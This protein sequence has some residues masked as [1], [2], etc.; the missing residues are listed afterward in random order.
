[1]GLLAALDSDTLSAIPPALLQ[2]LQQLEEERDELAGRLLESDAELSSLRANYQQLSQTH[3]SNQ[4]WL[5]QL[6]TQQMENLERRQR[7][8]RALAA[9]AA[10]RA[11]A[12]A[13]AGAAVAGGP[14]SGGQPQVMS[15]VPMSG[16]LDSTVLET[17]D[18]DFTGEVD[19][20]LLDQEDLAAVAASAAAAGVMG[21]SGGGVAGG[22]AASL[23]SSPL[24]APPSAKKLA[25][26]ILGAAAGAAAAPVDVM[27]L[28]GEQAH[29]TVAA[30]SPPAKSNA[31]EAPKSPLEPAAK[32]AS[33][34]AAAESHVAA[35]QVAGVQKQAKGS[36]KQKEDGRKLEKAQAA[37]AAHAA[38]SSAVPAT[39]TAATPPAT[40]TDAASSPA[41]AP[42]QLEAE[43]A[44]AQK[45]GTAERRASHAVAEEPEPTTRAGV[46]G[47]TEVPASQGGAGTATGSDASRTAVAEGGTP[48]AAPAAT[49][50]SPAKPKPKEASAEAASAP[51]KAAKPTASKVAAGGSRSAGS[52]SSTLV[53]ALLVALVLAAGGT[54]VFLSGGFTSSVPSGSPAAANTRL[55]GGA[56]DAAARTAAA[57]DAAAPVV[58]A[59]G[60]EPV[61]A[62]P[63]PPPPPPPPEPP[64]LVPVEHGAVS[65]EAGSPDAL[66]PAAGEPASDGDGAADSASGAVGAAPSTAGGDDDHVGF[67]D[68]YDHD[69]E[70]DDPDGDEDAGAAAAAA[71]SAA[72]DAGGNVRFATLVAAP[73]ALTP[74]QYWCADA[75]S[76]DAEGAG[77]GGEAGGA[78]RARALPPSSPVWELL[79]AGLAEAAEAADEPGTVLARPQPSCESLRAL[80][81]SLA[82]TDAELAAIGKQPTPASACSAGSGG[83]GGSGECRLPPSKTSGS[84]YP[85]DARAELVKLGMAELEKRWRQLQRTLER[86]AGEGDAKD[87]PA[88]AQL[89]ADPAVQAVASWA[90]GHL[91]PVMAPM[92]RSVVDDDELP[93]SLKRAHKA[94]SDVARVCSE[95]GPHLSTAALGRLEAQ[96][97]DMTNI[98]LVHVD[99]GGAAA[100]EARL[101]D[102]ARCLAWMAP[103]AEAEACRLRCSPRG[104]LVGAL[105]RLGIPRALLD[106]ALTL[107]RS[108][109]DDRDGVWRHEQPP[110]E[111]A[112]AEDVAAWLRSTQHLADWVEAALAAKEDG[113]GGGGSA[114]GSGGGGAWQP[115]MSAI[116]AALNEGSGAS[117]DWRRLQLE[118]AAEAEAAQRLPAYVMEAAVEAARRAFAAQEGLYECGGC[119]EAGEGEGAGA[120][121]GGVPGPACR[122]GLRT[123]GME[124]RAVQATAGGDA[125]AAVQGLSAAVRR[126]RADVVDLVAAVAVVRARCLVAAQGVL[127]YRKAGLSLG[128]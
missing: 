108:G 63:P 68:V 86:L 59:A 10:T 117:G 45:S 110:G 82:A 25:A 48:S 6:M 99:G 103:R 106:G 102:A 123:L 67:V 12:A 29:G 47:K 91:L 66:E 61:E 22:E 73:A 33:A 27:A 126:I 17:G 111:D 55:A 13:G 97:N 121:D 15:V 38:E 53:L 39:N 37:T 56:A 75:A 74:G 20:V 64:G 105:G 14:A 51:R 114:V 1:M 124:V 122:A 9:M 109:L 113:N 26:S 115:L 57:D 93:E 60:L 3:A 77:G 104:R 32:P 70:Y 87:G 80:A 128:R 19:S 11:A 42:E 118:L 116:G 41:P 2:R 65:S 98:A 76:C 52:G 40:S 54:Y 16:L 94:A 119:G 79:R 88:T 62:P 23:G 35:T 36:S 24:K 101:G 95:S 120:E 78:G 83:G 85:V 44:G 34:A 84:A 21:A 18:F 31:R 127:D 89:P 58:P 112:A 49:S 43:K 8:Q 69:D 30:A 107:G 4:T 90:L 50:A 72:I 7:R 92:V 125:A 28:A 71:A 96:L 100:V 81:A 46:I 5:N